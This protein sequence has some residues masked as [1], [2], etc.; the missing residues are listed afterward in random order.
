MMNS[1]RTL[2]VV[3][4]SQSTLNFAF[5]QSG[6]FTLETGGGGGGVPGATLVSHTN[7]WHLRKGTNVPQANWH[8]GADASLDTTWFTGAGDNQGTLAR[9]FGY[10]DGDDANP[11][12]FAD[13]EDGYFTI[14]ARRSFQISSS[15][16]PAQNLRLV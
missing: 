5:A 4:I 11:V 6:N 12:L 10:V 1:F 3:L 2:L 14:F 16:D 15:P 8:S 9:G 13:M 7:L